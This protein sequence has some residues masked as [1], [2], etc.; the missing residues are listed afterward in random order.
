MDKLVANTFTADD[1]H[2][3]R[4]RIA[5]RYRYMT[6]DEAERDFKSHVDNAKKTMMTLRQKKDM[7]H[8]KILKEGEYAQFN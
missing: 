4:L 3:L 2:N 5:E 8:D 6:P 1:I 7:E